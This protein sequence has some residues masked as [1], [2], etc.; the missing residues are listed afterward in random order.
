MSVLT[1]RRPFILASFAIAAAPLLSAEVSSGCA[2]ASNYG[3]IPILVPAMECPQITHEDRTANGAGR[4]HIPRGTETNISVYIA[5]GGPSDDVPSAMRLVHWKPSIATID[6]GCYEVAPSAISAAAMGL[7]NLSSRD[8]MSGAVG[9][10]L[11]SARSKASAD[12]SQNPDSRRGNGAKQAGP[13]RSSADRAGYRSAAFFREADYAIRHEYRFV[14]R[15]LI[16]RD[17]GA[18]FQLRALGAPVSPV[19]GEDAG[20][21]SQAQFPILSLA[22]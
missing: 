22:W 9:S 6:A 1:S 21:R 12:L 15:Y 10:G 13:G 11:I 18:G 14:P 4:Y 16:E 5:R 20:D 8:F 2:R 17:I 19:E 7:S 3:N